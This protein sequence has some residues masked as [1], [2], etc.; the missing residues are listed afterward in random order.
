MADKI[1]TPIPNIETA[2]EDYGGEQVE[3]FLKNQLKELTSQKIGDW[4]LVNGDDG[5]ATLYGFASIDTKEQ[6][7]QYIEAGN[8]EEA[9]KLVLSSVSFYSQ[10]V[11]DDYTLAARITKNLDSPMVMGADN[12]I[13]FTYNCY[14][15]GDPTDVDTLPGY[16]RFTVNGTQIAALNQSLTPGSTEH[17]IN[18]GPYLTQENNTVKMEIGNQHGKSRTWNFTVRAL[19]IVLYLD[20]SYEESLVRQSDWRLRVGC[21]GVAA[22]VHL[23]IDG[24]EVATSTITNSTYDFPVD[25]S[26]TLSAGVHKIELYA[27]N[28]TYNL[29]S[30][31]ITTSFIKAGLSTPS[32]CIGKDA[33][34]A[35]KLYGTA[36]IP[37]FFYYPYASAGSAVTVSFELRSTSGT[38]LTSG[39]TQTVTVKSD[40]TSGMQEW[41]ALIADN[42]YL[43]MGEVV[44]VVKIGST[45]AT[46][47]IT[48][49]DAGVTLEPA[50]E[51]KVYLSPAGKTNADSDAENWKTEYNGEI[52]C[53]VKRS[54]NFKLTGENGFGNDRFLIKSGKSITLAGCYPFATDFGV[55]ATSAAARTGK[56][57]EFEFKTLNCTNSDA[58]VIEC[59]NGGVG[60]VIYAN[61]VELHCAAGV[62]ETRYSDE[63]K[64]R[65]GFCIDGTTTHC[66]NKLIDGTIESDCNIAYI[67]VNGVIVRMED[68]ATAGWRQPTAQ[69]IVIGSSDCDIELYAVR[70][71]DKSLNY[72]QMVNNFAFDTPDLEEKIAIAK[73]NNV[74]DSTNAVDFAKVIAALPNTP[75]KIWEI[76]R[77]PTGKKD[78]VK[79]NTEFV[80]PTWTPEDGHACASFDCQQHDIAL[81]GTSSLSYPDP[82]KNWAN[83]YNGVWTLH[84]GDTDLVITKYSITVGVADAE[85]QFVDKVNFASSE[86]I[87]NILA[88]NAYQAI[89]VNA[90]AQYPNLLTPQQA[91]QQAE[92][93]DITYR[94]SLSG[95]PEIGWLR[96]YENGTPSVRFLSLFNFINN[97]YSASIFGFD[98]SGDAEA[99]EVEDN[100]NFFMDYLDEGT[101]ENG[102]WNCL[103]TTLYYARI[104]KTS[105]TTDEDYGTAGNAAQVTQANSEN[106]WLRRFHNWIV[107]CNPHVADRHRLRYGEYANLSSPV[108]YGDTTYRQ[109]T[110]AYRLAKFNAEYADYM[111]KESALF[112]LNFCDN[113]LC[114]DSFDKNMTIALVR[115]KADGP[116]I[117][118]FFLRDT[119]TSKMF[120]NR[121]PLAFRFYHEWG[122]SF[123]ASTG[124]TG[125]VDGETYDPETQQYNV[126][127]TV[128]TPVYNGRLSGLF[129]CVNMA[130]VA[131]RRAMYQAMRS[132]GLN[133]TDL[134]AMYNAFWGQWCEALYNTDGMGYATT[135]RFD[136]AYGDKKEIYKY[137]Y[138]YRQRYMDSKFNA[139]TSQALELRL[140]G[141]GA[142]VALRHYC[143]IYASL[144]WGAGD[145]K[146]VRSLNPGQPAYFPTSGN[147]NTETTFTVYDADLLT[148]ITT[149][150][151]LP[152]GSIA[153]SGLQ[154]ISTSLD[155]TGLE[156]CKRLKELVLDYS[157][158]A[159]NT[160]LSNRVTNVGTSKALE[161]LV[162]RN[163][164]NVTGSFNLQSEQ[165]QEVD[166]R[167]TNASG[168]TIPETDSLLSVQLGANMRTLTLNGMG[169]LSTLTLQGHSYLTKL[170]IN[171]CPKAKT[172]ELLES[173]LSDSSNVLADLKMRG[174]KWN[175]F[176][177][178]YLEQ[179]TDMKLANQDCEITGEISVI[180]S[181]NF[182]LKAK[183]IRAWGD[184]DGAGTLKINYTKRALTGAT[185]TG[186][187]YM[188]EVGKY[189]QLKIQPD[190]ISANRFTA[191]K[192]SISSTE[193]GTINAESGTVHVTK[194]GE[195]ANN[196]S[197]TVTCEI[198]TDT[199]D[200]ITATRVI[201]FYVR[202]CKVGDI[203]FHDGTFSDVIDSGKTP[204][205]VC[206]Y[207]N[208]EDKTQRLCMA[209]SNT[210]GGTVWGLYRDSS[211]GSNGFASITLIDRPAYSCFDIPTI[212]NITNRGLTTDYI[213]EET[214]RDETSAGDPDGYKYLTGAVGSIGF[215]EAP[216]AIGGYQRGEAMPIGLLNTLRIVAHRDI[217]L[218]DPALDELP[219]PGDDGAPLY[220][221]LV[222]CINT[223]NQIAPK[224]R[225]YYYPAA[226][227]CNAYEPG[228]K[229]GETLAD[230]FKQG[231]WFLPAE[232][233]LARMYWLH[234]F[235]YTY[236]E[237]GAKTPLQNAAEA[238]VLTAISNTWYWSS[239]ELSEYSAW[240]VNFS[241]GTTYNF[242]K[243][244]STA[245][246]AVAAF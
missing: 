41:R 228:V 148:K 235:G 189:Y 23:L 119:D 106:Y 16:V 111:S 169:N 38:V 55:N 129:D 188:A 91:Q 64:V 45:E 1:T 33:D 203:V 187:I 194:I 160:N 209:L 68:Y 30:E 9:A 18:L 138:R 7:Q 12:V 176:A 146:T 35:V 51:C 74:L 239:T 144:N 216:E 175:G 122:D 37:Y 182:E 219:K 190:P 172:R 104:P 150:V 115:Q 59:L 147:N 88:M 28:S 137:F 145:I 112:Y 151:D 61:R 155:I 99:W 230:C 92:G 143:P 107:E 24:R 177:V 118:Y 123:D 21:R 195:E 161:K 153:E 224:Y 221:S 31:T 237:D 240:Y 215:T 170:E 100:V 220:Q 214:Y 82:Y 205:G 139:N 57:L 53:T 27:E 140:W 96:T 198:T 70:I 130:W 76:P 98:E 193:Y 83:K 42:S 164:P 184:V 4:H 174:I 15:G 44:A 52:T 192:W 22:L 233:D 110:P 114:T 241:N 72:Q 125:T 134:M 85:K 165:I 152:D 223:A 108:T 197:A 158:K 242:I 225:Q 222:N 93:K 157:E 227:L 6:W 202:S 62:I 200:V 206:F 73:R 167:D 17:S 210:S 60:F 116:K 244:G 156:F 95:F 142:G 120:N 171:E 101:Y 208:P 133:A 80:N 14:Y 13:K 97:K 5:I 126:H 213:T 183:L 75:Y 218:H 58:K 159:A 39:A 77:M 48:V 20:N 86:G 128:G 8:A 71:Y 179:L 166:L 121:G 211:N 87:S 186:D 199:G 207:I 217:I 212:Q 65:V 162:I 246:R 117:A 243:Y 2:W 154:A 204:V 29:R 181:V 226:S 196:P 238:G 173:I 43:E 229:S 136:M 132:A 50:T 67:Y 232:G 79:S 201:G 56:T 46:H 234:H 90:S 113:D 36:S 10:P 84:L 236:D 69:N 66:V 168:L 231:K 149:Y 163:C 135:G 180:G 105:P 131:D 185:I 63:E 245:V 25:T 124:E 141:P 103:A 178:A 26:D 89:L 54:D 3:A 11:Q 40:G 32:V 34:R 109:D 78:W 127:C 94:H 102:A 81:D 49:E 47:T 191:V 19:E